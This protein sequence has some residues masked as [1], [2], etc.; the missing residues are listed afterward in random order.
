M[1]FELLVGL[2][3]VR[4]IANE[5]HFVKLFSEITIIIGHFHKFKFIVFFSYTLTPPNKFNCKVNID[6]DADL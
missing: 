4:K 2:R 6:V 1:V 5:E 3:G